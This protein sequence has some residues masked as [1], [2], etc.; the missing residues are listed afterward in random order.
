[1]TGKPRLKKGE[2]AKQPELIWNAF[3]EFVVDVELDDLNPM[4]RTAYLT[5]FYEAEVMN[6]GHLQYFENKSVEFIDETIKALESIGASCQMEIL[7][8]AKNVINESSKQKPITSA[9]E[10]VERALEGDYEELD[11]KFYECQPEI[12]DLL[13]KYVR[14]NIG[15][16]IE[17]E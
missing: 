16:F 1:M 4:Q 8:E 6:G 13:E 15:E 17:I 11:N 3:I 7:K 9:D 10:F 12:A 5:F 2:V 14:E